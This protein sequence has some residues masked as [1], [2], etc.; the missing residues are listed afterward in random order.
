MKVMKQFAF[1][2]MEAGTGLEAVQLV[3]DSMGNGVPFDAIFMDNSMPGMDGPEATKE[4]RK[5]GFVGKI[6]GV[7]GHADQ[8]DIES[9]IASG[10]DEVL[11]KPVKIAKFK[12]VL[13]KIGAKQVEES[14]D[15]GQSKEICL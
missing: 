1:V 2:M 15:A 13:Q 11:V 5:L 3:K 8:N 10:A 6:F 4:I 7:T 9:F 12:D 14:S